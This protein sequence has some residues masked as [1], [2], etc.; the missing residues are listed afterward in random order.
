MTSHPATARSVARSSSPLRPHPS[1]MPTA[2]GH[3]QV[4]GHQPQ[5]LFPST[6]RNRNSPPSQFGGAEH[7]YC[8][9]EHLGTSPAPGRLENRI[10]WPDYSPVQTSTAQLL[11][12][13]FLKHHRPEAASLQLAP[14]P[15][16]PRLPLRT[17]KA[18]KWQLPDQSP[19]PPSPCGAGCSGWMRPAALGKYQGNLQTCCRGI[20][21]RS[22]GQLCRCKPVPRHSP[23][24]RQWVGAALAP[25]DHLGWPRHL[26]PWE[27]SPG[28][29]VQKLLPWPW[30][31]QSQL[32]QHEELHRI[33][34]RQP[35]G[36]CP[37]CPLR[38]T[39]AGPGS[40]AGHAL[41][42]PSPRGAAHGDFWM[43]PTCTLLCLH[44]SKTS[45]HELSPAAPSTRILP[46]FSRCDSFPGVGMNSQ[47]PNSHPLNAPCSS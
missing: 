10:N 40:R 12:S 34:R 35:Q 6:L 15:P 8:S 47:S 14:P 44:S 5:Q 16:R 23:R 41:V 11:H 37:S 38:D 9:A 25:R 46:S 3:L 43:F 20:R 21:G 1:G 29:H 42:R 24:T 30:L 7:P 28:R 39:E 36:S 27:L 22:R 26:V 19:A 17:P 18:G 4:C 45:R 31:H 2:A 33:S 13:G 32:W